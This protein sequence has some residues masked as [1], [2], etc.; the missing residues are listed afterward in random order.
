[1]SA[2]PRARSSRCRVLMITISTP[3]AAAERAVAC[4]VSIRLIDVVAVTR[5]GASAATRRPRARLAKRAA[6]A[7]TW[8]ASRARAA[9][10]SVG[11][12]RLAPRRNSSS[13]RSRS[14]ILSRRAIVASLRRSRTAARASDPLS[15]MAWK[16]RRSSQPGGARSPSRPDAAEG[17]RPIGSA[18]RR[19]KAMRGRAVRASACRR[20]RRDHGKRRR[21]G[22]RVVRHRASMRAMPFPRSPTALPANPATMRG[23]PPAPGRAAAITGR[24]VPRRR[25]P[26]PG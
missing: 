15:A 6:A 18:A 2:S 24:S 5:T 14:R 9:P 7:A 11:I 4:F 23:W 21:A 8:S 25:R 19:A 17:G 16:I 12:R 22:G 13:P 26:A 1:M 3:P 10:A 20:Y